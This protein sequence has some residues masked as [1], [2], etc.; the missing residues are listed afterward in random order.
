MDKYDVIIIGAGPAGSTAGYLLSKFG[1]RVLLIDKS[2]FPR[3]KLCG[4]LLTFKTYELI[5]RIF[6]LSSNDFDKLINFSS[7]TFKL[8]YKDNLLLDGE[9]DKPFYFVERDKYD[10]FFVGKAKQQGAEIIEGERVVNFKL[11]SKEIIT[12][13]QKRYKAKFI[14]GADGVNSII[15]KNLPIFDHQKWKNDLSIAIEIFVNDLNIREPHLYLGFIDTGYG[16][17][18]PNRN[19]TIVGLGG[20]MKN[21]K[22]NF[23]KK[24]KDFL[25]KLDLKDSDKIKGHLVPYGNFIEKPIYRNTILIG[26]AAGLVDPLLGEGIFYAHRSG[27]IAAWSIYYHLKEKHELEYVYVRLLEKYLLPQLKYAKKVRK[28]FFRNAFAFRYFPFR[29]F[30]KIF[31]DQMMDIVH[32]IKFYNPLK[33]WEKCYGFISK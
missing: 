21:Q 14:I 8:Y 26:D 10:L 6:T 4:G 30:L 32:G 24:I 1:L 12:S 9:S 11:S 27:E 16:W 7:K 13:S 29:L 33:R 18:F 2:N 17:I 31:Q 23:V 25:N 22:E 19:K 28:M 15:R 3:Q 20:L 5:K